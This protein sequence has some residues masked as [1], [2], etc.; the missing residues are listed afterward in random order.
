MA[1]PRRPGGPKQKLTPKARAAKAK[2]DLKTAKTPRRTAMK[3]ENQRKRRAATKA[4]RSVSGKDY[5]H[6]R[7]R[8]VS[9]KTNRSK[10]KTTNNT[11][12]KQKT[13]PTRKSKMMARAKAASSRKKMAPKKLGPMPK[14]LKARMMKRKATSNKIRGKKK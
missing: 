7:G 1:K 5:D 2:R 9:E 6:N 4:G 14:G 10:T 11:M 8:F 3:S 13:K 12:G